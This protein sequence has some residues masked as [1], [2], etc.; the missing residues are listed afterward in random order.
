M[1]FRDHG[2]LEQ[3]NTYYMFAQLEILM[4]VIDLNMLIPENLLKWQKK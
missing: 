3:G 4:V 2:L 1:V